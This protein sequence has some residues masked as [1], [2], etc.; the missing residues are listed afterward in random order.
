MPPGL[1]ATPP[2]PSYQSITARSFA[3][4]R[5][6]PCS[7]LGSS[8]P[9]RTA[10]RGRPS[11]SRIPP[12]ILVAPADAL[13]LLR[14]SDATDPRSIPKSQRLMSRFVS[15][16]RARWAY[17]RKQRLESALRGGVCARCGAR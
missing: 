6:S 10:E 11:L 14:E 12:R 7:S 9:S 5:S 3:V 2:V 17:T 8:L 13:I 1:A 15:R 16:L 4:V